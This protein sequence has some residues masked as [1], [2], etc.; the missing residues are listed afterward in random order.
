MK[1]DDIELQNIGRPTVPELNEWK[2]RHGLTGARIALLC[3]VEPRTVRQ[4]LSGDR[5]IPIPCW[6]LLR[7][8]LGEITPEEQVAEVERFIQSDGDKDRP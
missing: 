6:R 5:R 3:G 8:M 1:N 7:I 2:Q 4:W